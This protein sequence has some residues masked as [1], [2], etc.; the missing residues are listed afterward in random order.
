MG[1]AFEWNSL[2]FID[3]DSN[4]D[5]RVARALSRST[6]GVIVNPAAYRNVIY[7]DVIFDDFNQPVYRRRYARFPDTD[8]LVSIVCPTLSVL[9]SIY[10]VNRDSS[11]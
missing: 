6:T 8:R 10:V 9:S 3:T 7:M 4:M 11:E 1:V 5:A 2:E